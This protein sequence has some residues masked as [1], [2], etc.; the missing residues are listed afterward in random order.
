[1]IHIIDVRRLSK[2][3]D[4][5]PSYRKAIEAWVSITTPCNWEKPQD[6]VDEYGSKAVDI[7][8]NK[9]G[10]SC[11]RAVIDIRGNNLRI[12]VKYQFHPKLNKSRLYLCWIGTHKN[13][14]KLCS[15]NSQYSINTF[16]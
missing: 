7:L 1:M 5:N 10:V 4:K 13:Y 14:D 6:I 8:P 2:F 15:N 9:D 3:M 16:K 12:I 11:E